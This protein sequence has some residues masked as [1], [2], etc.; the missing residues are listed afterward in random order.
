MREIS[1]KVM[2]AMNKW[3]YGRLLQDTQP[4]DSQLLKGECHNSEVISC[5]QC[6]WVFKKNNKSNR[7]TI[8]NVKYHFQNHVYRERESPIWGW[9]VVS[10]WRE[11]LGQRSMCS[12][13]ATTASE[14][15]SSWTTG[16][17]KLHLYKTNNKYL[18]LSNNFCSVGM[19]VLSVRG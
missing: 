1:W 6:A 7:F 2:S 5:L 12:L 15:Q 4:N 10:T 9:V 14:V 13:S 18:P 8:R 19:N 11:H 16:M 3:I 17:F